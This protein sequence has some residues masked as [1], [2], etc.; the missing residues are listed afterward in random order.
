VAALRLYRL[1]EELG[2]RVRIVMKAFPLI[3]GE[4]P[5]RFPTPHTVQNRLRA[6][7]EGEREGAV[8]RP[9]PQDR[10]LPSSSIPALEAA[11]CALLQGEEAFKRYDLAL[12][13]AFFEDCQD[14]SQRDVLLKLAQDVGLDTARFASD[15]DSGS[16]RSRVMGDFLECLQK[17]GHYASGIPLQTFNES[18]PLVGCAPIEVYRTAILR[19]LE[20]LAH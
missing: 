1:K 5:G 10:P 13:R 17:Y 6:G 11:K 9:W 8:F 18:P 3:P 16:Q 2:E 12:F 4:E 14:I 20:P 7:Q 19:Q 15:L